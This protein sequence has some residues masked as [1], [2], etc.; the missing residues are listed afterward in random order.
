MH[1][2]NY[3]F[4]LLFTF[5]SY[6]Y[7]R[8]YAQTN[9]DWQPIYLTPGGGNVMEGVEA[10]FRLSTCNN[11][12]II[13]VRFVNN[14]DYDVELKWY[15]AV[16]TQELKWINKDQPED[17]KVIIVRSKKEAKAECS[18]ILYPELAVK[19]KK[20]VDNRKDVKRYLTSQFIVISVQ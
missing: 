16:F 14:N 10:S 6:S 19:V 2:R 7:H 11:E 12:D 4:V 5:V 17:K 9:S 1:K 3:V 8:V 15:D 20:F 18:T 13:Y